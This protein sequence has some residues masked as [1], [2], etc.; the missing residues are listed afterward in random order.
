MTEK[1]EELPIEWDSEGPDAILESGTISYIRFLGRK[2][3]DK[4]EPTQFD[5]FED[6]LLAWL[7]NLDSERD[8]QLLLRLLVDLF[9]V[10][11]KEFES[12][13][14]SVYTGTISKWII[15]ECGLDPF[16]TDINAEI[17]NHLNQSWIC[18]ITDSLRINSFLKVCNLKGTEY[19]PDW[20]SMAVF[21]D[22][23]KID[24]FIS[25]NKISR[26]ILLEDFVGS[27]TQAEDALNFI[28][29]TLS[30]VAV[31]VC[32]LI[33]CPSGHLLFQDIA[34]NYANFSYSPGMVIPETEFLKHQANS[35]DS[36]FTQQLR[37]LFKKLKGTLNS[38]TI[39][40]MY[41]FKGTG[42]QVTMYSNCPNNTLLVYHRDTDKW[43]ALFP[44][45]GRV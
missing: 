2:L 42:A 18:P 23:S 21:A 27:G 14:R 19:R 37:E 1:L 26:L 22:A 16:S 28:G 29:E 6:R 32:P 45:V 7:N 17:R 43:K 13:Y 9:F 30:P 4:Y 5:A 24:S 40:G 31:L 41:G 44:R 25:E 10:G 11:R 20:K 34:A 8:R 12:L 39:K 15:D 35:S 36:E 33:I 3:F 38:S